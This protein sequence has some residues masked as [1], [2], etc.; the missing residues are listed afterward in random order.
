MHILDKISEIF[1]DIA[2]GT[3]IMPLPVLA[4]FIVIE[5]GFIAPQWVKFTLLCA[6]SLIVLYLIGKGFREVRL[7]EEKS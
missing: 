2:I 3:M 4:C 7:K 1:V 6:T 5:D